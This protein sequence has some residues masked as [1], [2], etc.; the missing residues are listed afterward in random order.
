M[1]KKETEDLAVEFA[2]WAVEQWEKGDGD[3]ISQRWDKEIYPWLIERYAVNTINHNLITLFRKRIT[4]ICGITDHRK[5]P[6]N[7]ISADKYQIALTNDE[8]RQRVQARARKKNLIKLTTDQADEILD[9]ASSLLKE[10]PTSFDGVGCNAVSLGL[11]TGRRIESEILTFGSFDDFDGETVAFT[12]Q[13]KGGEVKRQSSY[14]IPILGDYDQIQAKIKGIQKYTKESKSWRGDDPQEIIRNVS[15]GFQS[16]VNRIARYYFDPFIKNQ[17]KLNPEI[18]TFT[19]HSTRSLY[20]AMVW[21]DPRF[22]PEGLDRD[23]F[24]AQIL[25]HRKFIEI[26]GV[27]RLDPVTSKSY[28]KF[29]IGD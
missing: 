25:G 11:L 8:Y 19:G 9:I 13:S 4:E 21:L 1:Y 10:S 2:V 22:N 27:E 26:L 15:R 24:F 29:E 12:G 16:V 6:L 5:P 20:A 17:R 14:R 28:I 3:K 7:L 23:E 18:G